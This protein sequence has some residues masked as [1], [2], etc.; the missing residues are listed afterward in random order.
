MKVKRI[1]AIGGIAVL[2][3]FY[4]AALI[5]AIIGRPNLFII[6]LYATFVVPAVTY[7]LIMLYKWTH[8]DGAIDKLQADAMKKEAIR[9]EETGTGTENE[10]KVR[11]GEKTEN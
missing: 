3:G 6:A 10:A 7:A 2:L 5:G 1:L 8:K 9:S 4:V 11:G